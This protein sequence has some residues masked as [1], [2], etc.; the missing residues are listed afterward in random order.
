MIFRIRQIQL[1]LSMLPLFFALFTSQ[2]AAAA[3]MKAG[4]AKVDITP[5]VGTQMWGYFDR[6][7]GA[8]GTLDPLFARVLVLEA[9]DQRLAYVDL[10]LG[11]T[12]GPGSLNHL[13][14][15]AKQRSGIDDL[16]VQATHTHAGPVILDEYTVGPPAWETADLDRI[17]GAIDDAAHHMVPVRLGVGYG[18]AYIGYNRRLV[19]PDGSISMLWSNTTKAPT[20]PVDPLLAVLRIDRM[21]G[22]M[23]G[24]PLALLVNYAAHP[25]TFGSDDLRYS[26]DFP[27]VMCSVIEQAFG[28]KPTAFF[29]QGAP[30]DIN[31]F[32]AGTPVNLDVI[33]RRDWAGQTLAKAAIAAAQQIDT[34]ADP[35]PRIDFAEDQITFKLRWD[36]EKFRQ[37]ELHELGPKAFQ[38][39]AAPIKETWDLPVTT[40]LINR[41]IAILGMPGEPFVDFQTDYRARCPVSD[42]FFLGYTNGY[43]GYFPTLKAAAEGGY[44][45]VSVTTWV[46]VGAGERM[47]NQG[48]VDIYRMLGRLQDVPNSNWKNLPPAP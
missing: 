42:C 47:E 2:L 6:L 7:A 30:G 43:Y 39:F 45:A 23:D 41:K 16:I 46:E 3:D 19:N 40:A 27:G 12:F 24:Q 38:I 36:P 21:G 14:T 8:E 17:A 20:S 28:G 34:V 13:R 5:P 35:D 4:V 25:V 11:R 1:D 32:D 9:G 37:E 22:Q 31:V 44:G 18:A 29:V 10:D 26:A 33:G 15:V 48:L